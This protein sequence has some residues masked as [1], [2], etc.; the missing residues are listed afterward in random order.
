MVFVLTQTFSE[1]HLLLQDTLATF[2]AQFSEGISEF[3]IIRLLQNPPYS[4]LEEDALRD[5]LIL[6]QTHFILFNCLYKLRKQWRKLGVGELDIGPTQIILR[7]ST[8][9]HTN[10]DAGDPLADYYLEW[11]N[12]T[13][14]DAG[15]V[16]ALLDSFWQ[17]MAGVD[18][19]PPLSDAAVKDA[20]LVM[21]FEHAEDL[22]LGKLKQQYRKLQHKHHPDKGG[23][24]EMSQTI[25]FAYTRLRKHLMKHA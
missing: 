7:Q 9:S 17:K 5:P 22:N 23:S 6:F 25:L 8:P 21:E 19:A 4:M 18:S 20:C 11:S 15:D 13:S 10:L 24:I 1:L 14:T 16:Q 12:L 2:Q 3:E